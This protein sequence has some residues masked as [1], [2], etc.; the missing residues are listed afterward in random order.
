ME[1]FRAA[2]RVV[3]LY[4]TQAAGQ[5]GD[6]TRQAIQDGCN[7]VLAAGGDGTLNEAINGIAGTDAV[8]GA[9]PAGTANVLA[10]EVG[11]PNRPDHAAKFLLDAVPT[12]IALGALDVPGLARRHFALMAGIGLDARIVREL[13]LKMKAK[14][15]KLA[16][17]HAGL[18]QMGRS[19][20]RFHAEVD[21]KLFEASFVLVTRVRNYGGD[22]EIAKQIRITDDDFEVVIFERH[23]WYDYLRAIGAVLTNSLYNTKGVTV[24]RARTIRLLPV[25]NQ[26]VFM[27]ADGEELGPIPATISVVPDS[28]TLLLP[29]RYAGR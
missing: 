18:C 4:P 5:A 3:T 25:P 22:L 26:P 20:E 8:F 27:Q 6:L 13:D 1:V 14:V 7:L 16:Y 2:G 29:K 28:L 19:L 24:C 11:L 12:R 23:A 15:G 17:W 10:N 9:L 21:G